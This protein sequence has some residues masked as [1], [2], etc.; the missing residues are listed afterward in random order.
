[1]ALSEELK[2]VL[3]K[4]YFRRPSR[5]DTNLIDLMINELVYLEKDFYAPMQKIKYILPNNIPT[6]LIKISP[7]KRNLST[8]AA[9]SA[10][11]AMAISFMVLTLSHDSQADSHHGFFWWMDK[12]SS[13][14]SILTSPDQPSYNSNDISLNSYELNYTSDGI[15]IVVGMGKNYNSNNY[16]F[17]YRRTYSGINVNVY[18]SSNLL[19]LWEYKGYDYYII[20]D[21]Y[22]DV[23]LK[24]IVDY[25]DCIK[26][27][28]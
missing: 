28:K 7:P 23:L 24:I 27:E 25:I 26:N 22:N 10:I 9:L 6:R 1:M 4:Q 5:L 11:V 18:Y 14:T 8:T 13:G 16:Q 20:A 19:F 15:S 17:R 3:Y 21:K 12:N 2:K